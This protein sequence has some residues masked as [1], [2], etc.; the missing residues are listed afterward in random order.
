MVVNDQSFIN[1]A[2]SQKLIGTRKIS[3]VLRSS[4]S[5]P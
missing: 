4:V 1:P 5:V 2:D 3:T